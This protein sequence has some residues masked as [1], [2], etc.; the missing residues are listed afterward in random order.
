MDHIQSQTWG[1]GFGAEK[2]R[3]IT[4][5]RHIRALIKVLYIQE[6]T[7]WI[8][9]PGPDWCTPPRIK[10]SAQL[11]WNEGVWGDQQKMLLAPEDACECTHEHIWRQV[12]LQP[13][14]DLSRQALRCIG[15]IL[16]Q[17]KATLL[18]ARGQGSWSRT[19][20]ITWESESLRDAGT[21]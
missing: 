13:R 2:S 8:V 1:W 5:Y 12:P 18:A 11:I 7:D 21:V 9:Y 6:I 17:H 19:T 16:A 4:L 14:S 15:E 3:V 10:H 20:P